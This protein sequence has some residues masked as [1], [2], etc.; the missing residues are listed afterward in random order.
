MGQSFYNS[1]LL[2]NKFWNFRKR[3]RKKYA[4][5]SAYGHL[6]S[7]DFEL[8]R[9]QNDETGLPAMLKWLLRHTFA[10]KSILPHYL[11]KVEH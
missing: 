9:T 8:G 4:E 7:C 3:P 11:A 1:L 2:Q 5:F 10:H 6:I